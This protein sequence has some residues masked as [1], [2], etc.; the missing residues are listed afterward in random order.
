MSYGDVH[1]FVI[2]NYQVINI[3]TGKPITIKALAET[4]TKIYN[5]TNLQ[6]YISNEYRKGDIRHCYADTTKAQKLLNFKSSITL[7][8]GLNELANWAKTHG[9]GAVDLFDKSL[10]ELKERHLA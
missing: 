8:D 7:E 1:P 2:T 3:G 9:W 6:P 5:K 10:R 4:L